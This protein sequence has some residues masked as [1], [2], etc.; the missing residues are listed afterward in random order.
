MAFA[1]AWPHGWCAGSGPLADERE[2]DL[3]AQVLQQ[4]GNY[5]EALACHRLCLEAGKEVRRCQVVQAA[6]AKRQASTYLELGVDTGD[7]LQHI[8]APV[9][10]WRGCVMNVKHP[11]HS[12]V[13]RAVWNGIVRPRLRKTRRPS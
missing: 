7:N 3:L 5:E 1:M 4:Q 6:I 12:S 9:A 8:L 13:S 11:A 10:M 2:H